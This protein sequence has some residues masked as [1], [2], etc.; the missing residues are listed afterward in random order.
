[1]A[2]RGAGDSTVYKAC[3]GADR[4]PAS[5]WT[6]YAVRHQPPVQL[7]DGLPAPKWWPTSLPTPQPQYSVSSVAVCSHMLNLTGHYRHTLGHTAER[8]RETGLKSADRSLFRV[9]CASECA[10]PQRRARARVDASARASTD[11]ER[12]QK[13]WPHRH[14]CGTKRTS[15]SRGRAEAESCF[16][17]AR[18]R[19][20]QLTGA[21][22]R[23]ANARVNSSLNA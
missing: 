13:R 15:G 18:S 3:S 9:D 17:C 6:Q 4:P 21:N 16:N 23:L 20:G 12:S 14:R 10:H 11:A 1:M 8:A 5:T 19:P 7:D 2:W 22:P